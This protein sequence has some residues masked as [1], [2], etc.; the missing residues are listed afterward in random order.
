MLRVN[1][2]RSV[3]AL[4]GAAALASPAQPALPLAVRSALARAQVPEDALSV[5]LQGVEDK[6]PRLAWQA[7][8]PMNP[9]SLF[10]LVTTQAALELLGPAFSW[11]TPV[12]L[13]GS[14]KDGVL[15]G[16]LVIKGQG[17]PKLVVERL[18]LLLRR[19][20][21]LGVREIRGDIVLDRSAFNAPDASPAE[22]DGEPLRP[23]NAR[24]DALLIN[25][26][27][28]IYSFTPDAAAGI[29]RIGSEPPLAGLQV[30]AQVPLAAGPCDDW[31]GA[32]KA[33][34][35]DAQRMRFAGSYA[36]SCGERS[37]P[38]AFADPANYNARVLQAMWRELGGTLSGSVRDGIAP[39]SAPG[40]VV[41]SP[42][43]SEV[44]RDIN[45]FSNNVMAQQLFLTL[46]LQLRG[47]GTPD[48]GRAVLRQWLAQT[49]GAERASEIV[50]DNGSGLSREGRISAEAMAALLQKA[51][52]SPTMPE[53]LSSLP[54][55]GLDGT[56]R[57]SQAPVG[58]A[59]LKTG[60]LR[61]VTGIAGYVLGADGRRLV[62]VAIVNHP[63]A[64]AA[65]PALDALVQWAMTQR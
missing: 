54:V 3:V 11:Q 22:F 64:G 30:D 9:A 37:W 23:Y 7:Q 21:Q 17:D 20:Q 50:V 34:P 49:L 58:R 29:A 65:R 32:L 13:Q 10:K 36:S 62:L 5:W 12:W 31:R 56:L 4:L 16:S 61:D 38:L 46:G 48:N 41:S 14:V 26:R 2:A 53:L 18:W 24:P 45:K 57:R 8:R 33:G 42:A 55:T 27:S 1:L 15:D 25:Y 28:V 63:Q 47:S 60:S 19:V 44:V 39:A 40:F 59:H 43:L 52:R 35:G 51:W 6:A